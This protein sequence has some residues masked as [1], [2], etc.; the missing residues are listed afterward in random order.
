[1]FQKRTLNGTD[2][3]QRGSRMRI[4]QRAP[5]SFALWP[6]G[7]VLIRRSC[8]FVLRVAFGRAARVAYCS[9]DGTNL[10]GV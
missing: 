9:D 7:D 6:A 10:G 8:G 4:P 2:S 3:L 1:M 5:L